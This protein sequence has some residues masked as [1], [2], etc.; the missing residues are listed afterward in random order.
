VAGCTMG[1]DYERPELPQPREYRAAVGEGES[2]ANLPWWELYRDTVLQRLIGVGLENNLSL[3]ESMA[4]IAEARAAVGI[5]RADLY[6][7]VSMVGLGFYQATPTKDS[8]S[9]FDYLKGAAAVGYEVE[10]RPS[11][12]PRRPIGP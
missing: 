8:V 6:P 1:P 7:T 2:V 11:W 3:R 5:A 12:P 10:L 4:R 9:S